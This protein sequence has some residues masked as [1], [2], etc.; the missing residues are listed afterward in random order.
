MSLPRTAQSIFFSLVL[1][2]SPLQISAGEVTLIAQPVPVKTSASE[3]IFPESWRK[4]PILASGGELPE[5]QFERV[6]QVLGPAIK[7]YPPQVLEKHLKAV[8]VLSELKYSGVV[9]SG[10][11]SRTVVY[12]KIGDVKQGFPDA[13][14]ESVFHAEFSSILLRNRKQDFDEQA[15]NKIN[16]PGFKYLGNGVDAVKQKKVGLALDEELHQQGFLKE[17]SQSTLENDFNAF[18]AKI[19]AGD[20]VIWRIA[21]KHP[22]IQQKLDLTLDFYK[23]LDPAFTPEYFLGLA[24]P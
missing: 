18:A 11:N 7:K 1:A 13:H 3:E 16:P 12:E 23:G 21:D 22:K 4:P 10:T 6:C 5:E 9:T 15:W 24:Q 2:L 14:V 19:F 8:Y 20:G 17:Y